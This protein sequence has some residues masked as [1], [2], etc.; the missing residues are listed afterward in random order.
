[1]TPHVL[2]LVSDL[3]HFAKVTTRG[4]VC[5]NPGKLVKRMNGGTLALLHIHPLPEVEAAAVE[6]RV[7]AED[8][9]MD[10]STGA[11]KES[12]KPSSIAHRTC[13]QIMRI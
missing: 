1:M 7:K 4:T 10:A 8:T 9:A 11:P 13:V 2:V 5:I 6:A 3:N 12:E